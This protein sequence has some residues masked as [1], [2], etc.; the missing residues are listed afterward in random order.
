MDTRSETIKRIK[1]MTKV[2]RGLALKMA[3]SSGPNGAHLGAGMSSMEIMATLYGGI[4][5]FDVNNPTWEKRDRLIVSKAHCVLS[6]Y[7]A[8]SQAGFIDTKDLDLFETNESYLPGHPVI[9]P[10]KGIEFSGGSLGMGLSL[11]VGL[12]LSA[13]MSGSEHRIYVLLGDGECDEGTIWE[14]AMSAAHFK[15]DNLVAIVDRNN[16]QYDGDT[17][18][19]MD[20][21][22][23][24][25]KWESFGWKTIEID[26]HNVSEVYDALINCKS[27]TGNPCVIIA[28][29]VKG[30]GVSFM[31]NKKEWHHSRLTKDQFEAALKE[32]NISLD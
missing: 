16:L 20:L 25:L 4:V 18:E 29:T 19:I 2:M 32:L 8:L 12:G 22:N 15:L 6:Y 28:N 26:G 13:K 21:G 10:E 7:T 1:D 11:G 9:N 31:E 14:A 27:Y 5:N 3:Y 24:G 17:H 30:K 23:I